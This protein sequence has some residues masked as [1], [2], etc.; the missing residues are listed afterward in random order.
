MRQGKLVNPGNT[1][2]CAVLKLRF[3]LDQNGLSQQ[4]IAAEPGSESTVSLVLSGKR[5]LHR[6]HITRLSQR[7]NTQ[8]RLALDIEASRYFFSS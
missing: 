3:F 2:D 5:L 4:D 8:L 7:L 1:S 6:D